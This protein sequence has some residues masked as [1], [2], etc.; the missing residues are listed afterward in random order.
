MIRCGS[1]RRLLEDKPDIAALPLG[2]ISQ[3]Q[4]YEMLVWGS[5]FETR[6]CRNK[7]IELLAGSEGRGACNAKYSS[8]VGHRKHFPSCSLL[9]VMPM[10]EGLT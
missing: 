3:G 7:A 6:T 10:E 1:G 5:R 8:A 2:T 9:Y 4:I